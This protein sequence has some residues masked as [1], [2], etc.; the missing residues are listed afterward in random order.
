MENTYRSFYACP[1]CMGYAAF[2]SLTSIYCTSGLPCIPLW[3]MACLIQ[4]VVILLSHQLLSRKS[5]Q[6]GEMDGEY[7]NYYDMTNTF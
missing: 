5:Y 6:E 7:R 2:L 1:P 4:I 3:R